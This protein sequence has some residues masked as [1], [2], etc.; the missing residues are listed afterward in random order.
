MMSVWCC[1]QR[2]LR[3]SSRDVRREFNNQ[4]KLRVTV[5]AVMKDIV[6]RVEVCAMAWPALPPSS[7]PARLAPP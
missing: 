4:K 1:R 3:E 2:E 6:R 7:A 5:N